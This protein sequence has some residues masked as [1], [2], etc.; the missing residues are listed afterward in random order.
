MTYKA[1]LLERL[2]S[3]QATIGVV[4][5]G[6][7]G[8]P[9]AVE[10]AEAGYTVIGYDL[11]DPKINRLNSGDSYIPDIPAERLAPLVEQKKLCGTTDASDL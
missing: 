2:N 6:Y 10:F 8:L 11:S 7:V 3:R 5:L 4:G 1:E 9:L